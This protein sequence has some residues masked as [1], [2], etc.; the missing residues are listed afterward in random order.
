MLKLIPQDARIVSLTLKQRT[1]SCP[2]FFFRLSVC[3]SVCET[4]V[5]RPQC[6][7]LLHFHTPFTWVQEFSLVIWYITI[8]RGSCVH[9]CYIQVDIDRIQI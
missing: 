7:C 5:F 4:L 2:V 6:F 1:L 9:S 3:V 8:A